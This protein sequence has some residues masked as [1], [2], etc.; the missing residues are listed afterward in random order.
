MAG[1]HNL[2]FAV[3]IV[4]GS[5]KVMSLR[6]EATDEDDQS[7]GAG[8]RSAAA[9]AFDRA[10]FGM[11]V[12]AFFALLT[13]PGLFW[14][15]VRAALMR[16][17]GAGLAVAERPKAI[18]ITVIYSLVLGASNF[19]GVSTVVACAFPG[20]A[21]ASL[22]TITALCSAIVLAWAVA[23]F[24]SW[25]MIAATGRCCDEGETLP[26]LPAW[27]RLLFTLEAFGFYTA[28]GSPSNTTAMIRVVF[29]PPFFLWAFMGLYGFIFAHLLLFFVAAATCGPRSPML[30][31]AL[32]WQ[33]PLNS[34][35]SVVSVPFIFLLCGL[36]TSP[37]AL[38]AAAPHSISDVVAQACGSAALS[39]ILIILYVVSKVLTVVET[40][41]QYFVRAL[42]RRQLGKLVRVIRLR[43]YVAVARTVL[44]MVP[45]TEGPGDNQAGVRLANDAMSQ[46]EAL[47]V[48]LHA[49]DLVLEELEAELSVDVFGTL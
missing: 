31:A 41:G 48:E 32:T 24:G 6:D 45:S 5:F 33:H 14:C 39:D 15:S 36:L 49:L 20:D 26:L 47:A 29:W 12:G 1:L 2:L 21:G 28:Q 16:A 46:R 27:A 7:P 9:G 35:L 19:L 44:P 17:N 42:L 34:F 37:F 11:Y 38:V 18:S 30:D 23:F 4:V 22:A 3:L 8:G 40:A 10:T 43:V 25:P 13:E